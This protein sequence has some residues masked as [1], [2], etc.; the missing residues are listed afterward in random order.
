MRQ[1]SLA[2]PV[3]LI[4]IGGIFLFNNI[5]PEFSVWQA[6]FRWWPFL[7]IGFGVVRLLEVL[8]AVNRGQPVTQAGISTGQIVLLVLVSIAVYSSTRA[9]RVFHFRNI[10]G[11]GMEIFGEQYDYPIHANG[12]AQG[13]TMLVLDNL[14]GNV[15]V[16]GGDNVA[17]SADGHKSIKAY[18]KGE[19]DQ[20]DGKTQIRFVREG[21]QLIV[22]TAERSAID[23]RNLST[24]IEIQVPRGVSV[25]ARG[26][27]GDLAV[28]SVTGMVDISSERGD[29]RLNDIGGNARVVVNR[30]G[31]VRA[32]G[33]KG[34]LDIEGKGRDVQLENISGQVSVNGTYS[35]TLEFKNLA[36]PLHFESDRTTLRIAQIAGTFTMDLGDIRANHLVGPVKL[37]TRSRDIHIEDFTDAMD[38]EIERGD[39]QLTPS[40]LPLARIDVRSRNGNVE[41]TLPERADFDL[42]ATTRQGDATNDYGSGVRSEVEGRSASLRSVTAKGP[43]INVA[44]DRGTVSVK[45][46]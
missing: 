21:T 36:Q 28:N 31:L 22:R 10:Q 35:G 38:I 29:I 12:D 15:T 42:H 30:S 40:K 13:I 11:S 33:L 7:L 19:A 9:N 25:E 6:I 32:I 20:L 39:I 26:R 2:A 4:A 3:I 34:N 5:H 37:K 23:A 44:T 8:F 45:K 24:D 18:N 41:L 14:R 27:T 16:N 43:A 46:S 1:R 17:Y